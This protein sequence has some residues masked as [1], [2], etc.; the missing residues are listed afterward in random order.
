MV[1]K[2]YPTFPNYS[3]L[4]LEEVNQVIYN[5]THE[6]HKSISTI[7][8]DVIQKTYPEWVGGNK[9]FITNFTNLRYN[10]TL[11]SMTKSYDTYTWTF[12]VVNTLWNG[13]WKLTNLD[14]TDYTGEYVSLTT[15]SGGDTLILQ[16]KNLCN[17]ILHLEMNNDNTARSIVSDSFAFE[18]IYNY[19]HQFDSS[20]TEYAM[21]KNSKNGKPVT[22]ATVKFIPLN[23]TGE[24][25]TVNNG[26]YLQ[27]F[28]GINKG[29]GR[30]A[31]TY[32]KVNS[33]G[34][35]YGRLEAYLNDVLIAQTMVKVNKIQKYK[36][37]VEV[38]PP[39]VV[40]PEVEPSQ[41][42]PSLDYSLDDM[43]IYKGGIKE[44]SMKIKAVNEY[45]YSG[46]KANENAVVNVYHTY[47]VANNDPF[48]TPRI[49]KMKTEVH[50]AITDKEGNFTFKL[51]S[52]N[53][54]TDNSYIVISLAKTDKFPAWSSSKINITHKVKVAT[55][56]TDLK[57]ECENIDGAD[58][59]VLE[60]KEYVAS[61]D[62]APIL[63]TRDTNN[64]YIVGKKGSTWSTV[65]FHNFGAGFIIGENKKL[66][67]RGIKVIN[68]EC[69]ISQKK[70]SVTDIISCAFL[71]NKFTAKKYIGS[72]IYQEDTSI[73]KVDH[74]FFEN[75]Y[76]NCVCGRGSVVLTNNL[77]KITDVK[78]TQQ[79]EPFVLEQ[80]SGEGVLK[81]NQIYVNTSLTWDKNGKAHVSV[82]NK[83]R[84]YA[85]I[86]VWVGKT[87]T[88]NGKTIKDLKGNSKFNF[89]DA[90]YNNKAYIFSAYYYPYNVQ[91]FIVASASNKNINRATGHAIYGTNWAFPDGYYL[92]R[93]S[94]KSYNTYNPFVKFVKGQKIVSPEITVPASGGVW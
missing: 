31:I 1:L 19:T 38:V 59:I 2:K 76:A 69:A 15:N 84:S 80:Y 56:Y 86:S 24:S 33:V 34:V 37:V 62:T 85:K 87:A 22:N 50:T 78:Y 75:N 49:Q 73:A 28:T 10:F 7:S 91:A 27:E 16:G 53:C 57:T 60:N 74:S 29:S 71:Y 41:P 48:N 17:F 25:I 5:Y 77:F 30:Y 39:K 44:F 4:Q 72:V 82:Y 18:G 51:S 79:P 89:F 12:K 68:A 64:Q 66:Y 3:F 63:I 40:P 13:W 92:V 70:N 93:E 11:I 9:K 47:D 90:P 26:D 46:N 61:K 35:Y 55:N 81:N 14:G 43:W 20:V 58:L 65:N 42:T 32:S 21:L 8:T 54:Y 36:R 52:R 83:N 45:N 67:I 88:V 6:G 94:A 23:D